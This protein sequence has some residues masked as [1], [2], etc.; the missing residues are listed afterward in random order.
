MFKH[1]FTVCSTIAIVCV[2]LVANSNVCFG[3]DE[4]PKQQ[5]LVDT[6]TGPPPICTSNATVVK[7]SH[8]HRSC[9]LSCENRFDLVRACPRSLFIG[10][11][12][13]CKEGFIYRT[14]KDYDCVKVEDC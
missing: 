14:N 2:C 6:F 4:T 5:Q 10:A 11:R 9:L 1:I 13:V 7:G 12:C 8:P 3:N